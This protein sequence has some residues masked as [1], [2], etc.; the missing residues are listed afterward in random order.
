VAVGR[1]GSFL[2]RESFLVT[3]AIDDAV[4][5]GQYLFEG[6]R[7]AAKVRRRVIE[8]A[9]AVLRRAHDAGMF[10]QDLHLDNLMVRNRETDCRVFLI[11]LQRVAFRRS[12]AFGARTIN[13]AELH[14]GCAGAS[15]S[16]RLRFLKTYLAGL[17]GVAKDL[18]PLLARIEKMA[19]RHRQRIWRSRQKRCLAENRDFVQLRLGPYAGYGRRDWSEDGFLAFLSR[20]SELL[21]NCAIVKDSRTTTVGAGTLEE[22]TIHVKRYNFQGPGYAFKDFFRASRAKRAWIAG[23][24]CLMRDISVAT[25]I[26]YLER[27]HG[28][29]LFESYLIAKTVEGINLV[30]MLFDGACS[31]SEKL[32][33]IEGLARYLARMHGHQV[34]NRDLKGNNLIVSRNPSGKYAFAMVDFD[35]V[36]IGP[37]SERTRVKNLARLEREFR[38]SA[39]VTRTDRARFLRAYLGTRFADRWK[40]YWRGILQQSGVD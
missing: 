15:A 23:N 40:K 36:K 3:E 7:A 24:C 34:A 9:A 1:R 38:R 30:E 19:R 18:R 12:L 29:I 37:V 20:P 17:S 6:P 11:D 13:L 2:G 16:E 39:T 27:R 25:P 31:I 21:S 35:G 4:P 22:R 28:R 33:L 32:V 26:A 8:K 10:H 14:G 5:L